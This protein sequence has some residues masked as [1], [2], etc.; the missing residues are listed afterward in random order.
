MESAPPPCLDETVSALPQAM[1]NI[2]SIR[3]PLGGLPV[4]Q[5]AVGRSPT[6]VPTPGE[7]VSPFAYPPTAHT[8][9]PPAVEQKLTTMEQSQEQLVSA[10]VHLQDNMAAMLSFQ[11]SRRK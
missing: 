10:L 7:G 8:S 4:G 2:E 3:S 1:G 6:M 11:Q 5:T 9:L